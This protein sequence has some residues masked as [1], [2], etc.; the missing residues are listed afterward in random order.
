MLRVPSLRFE[1]GGPHAPTCSKLRVLRGACDTTLQKTGGRASGHR[2]PDA[3][4]RVSAR[5]PLPLYRRLRV[6]LAASAAVGLAILFGTFTPPLAWVIGL[7]TDVALGQREELA[8]HTAA[9]VDEGIDHAADHLVAM[10]PSV[11]WEPESTVAAAEQPGLAQLVPIVSEFSALA[12][13]TPNEGLLWTSAGPDEALVL[14]DAPAV[15]EALE[16]GTISVS[17]DHPRVAQAPSVVVAVPLRNPR[18]ELAGALAGS[19]YLAQPGSGVLPLPRG[20][21]GLRAQII[22]QQGQVLDASD[23]VLVDNPDHLRLLESARRLGVPGSAV[24]DLDNGLRHIVGYAPLARFGGGVIIE[25]PEDRAL[26]SLRSVLRDGMLIGAAAAVL[27]ALGGWWYASRLTRPLDALTRSADT[28]AHGSFDRP[29]DVRSDTEVGLLANSFEEMRLR[30]K[31]SFEDRLRWQS[32]L[33]RQVQERTETVRRLLGKVISA[34]EEERRRIAR[35]LHDGPA[36]DLAALLVALDALQIPASRT[37]SRDSLLRRVRAQTHGTLRDIRHLLVDLRPSALDDLGLVPAVR[38]FVET[39][40]TGLNIEADVAT[41]DAERRL[42]PELENVLFRLVQEAVNNVVKHAKPR[43]L[44]VR[45]DLS[46]KV[47]VALVEDDGGGFDPS[48]IQHSKTKGLGLAGMHE[49]AALA[50]GTLEV[51]S[52]PGQGTR[53]TARIPV[54]EEDDANF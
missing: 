29:V 36:Q 10:E 5:A 50:G 52:Q 47:V 1:V 51:V 21:S 53:V 2:Q 6:R 38:W 49:R 44:R 8:L 48:V 22:N 12:I 16:S 19:L 43:R 15:A 31:E 14:R 34:Q 24:H 41:V 46:G 33:E 39:R 23:G 13:A 27:V 18:G 17:T 32:E 28:I 3:S 25:Q 42:P 30:L 20:A 35:E 40:L 4:A 7:S 26:V 37:A 54:L 45:L 11:V 9:M